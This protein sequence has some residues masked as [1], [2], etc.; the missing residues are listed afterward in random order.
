MPRETSALK[1]GIAQPPGGVGAVVGAEVVVEKTLALCATLRACPGFG[2]G[3][4]GLAN[5]C[6]DDRLQQ[7]LLVRGS[8]NT[9]RLMSRPPPPRARPRQLR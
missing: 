4:E 1:A 3:E 7:G 8:S 5:A 9:T 2:L 6:V